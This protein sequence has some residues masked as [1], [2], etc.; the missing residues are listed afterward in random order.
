MGGWLTGLNQR[1]SNLDHL[2]QLFVLE[3][4]L[5]R[6]EQV[7]KTQFPTRYGTCYQYDPRQLGLL[8]TNAR[9]QRDLNMPHQLRK[10]RAFT[11]VELLVVIAIIAILIVLL[12]PAVQKV[13][14]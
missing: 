3:S 12:L 14:D 13:R 6:V 9:Q 2:W 4:I 10:K 8:H 7:E 1:W 5:S 11:L